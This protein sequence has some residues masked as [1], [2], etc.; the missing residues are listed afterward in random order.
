MLAIQRYT[1][2]QS[3]PVILHVYI[4]TAYYIYFDTVMLHLYL[5]TV[6]YIHFGIACVHLYLHTVYCAHCNTA[7]VHSFLHIICDQQIEQ[8]HSFDKKIILT[9]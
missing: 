1:G 5:H 3:I 7:C 9:Y 2:C 4:H 8:K 6:H